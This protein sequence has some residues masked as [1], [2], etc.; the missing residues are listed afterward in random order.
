MTA[1]PC[2]ACCIDWFQSTQI[3]RLELVLVNNIVGAIGGVCGAVFSDKGMGL[4][5]V[6]YQKYL[7]VFLTVG[8]RTLWFWGTVSC[9]ITLIISGG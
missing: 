6:K 8:R 2:L 1:I 4:I 5:T 9:A 7:L 3:V